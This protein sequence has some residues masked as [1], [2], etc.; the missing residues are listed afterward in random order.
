M[1]FDEATTAMTP[2][3]IASEAKQSRLSSQLWIASSLRSQEESGPVPI[4]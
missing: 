1:I 4:N 2:G 3:V